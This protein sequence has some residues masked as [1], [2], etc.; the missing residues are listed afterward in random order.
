MV[1]KS[2]KKN[3][4][5]V[6]LFIIETFT[7]RAERIWTFLSKKWQIVPLLKTKNQSVDNT[8][9]WKKNTKNVYIIFACRQ[10]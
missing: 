3:Y 6:L 9:I 7:T 4:I 8:W 2:E 10:F 5:F 1:F